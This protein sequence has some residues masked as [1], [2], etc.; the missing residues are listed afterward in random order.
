[1]SIDPIDL[2]QEP[3]R[4]RY[5]VQQALPLLLFTLCAMGAI[6]V[7]ALRNFAQFNDTAA[8]LDAAVGVCSGQPFTAAAA[9][10]PDGFHPVVVFRQLDDGRVLGDSTAVPSAWQPSTPSTLAIVLCITADRDAYR[11]L[12]TVA[13]DPSSIITPYGRELVVT[14]RAA[15]TA[16]II[17][18]GLISNVPSAPPGCLRQQPDP[19]PPTTPVTPTDI[20]TWLSPW[21]GN[22]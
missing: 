13:G 9:Y 18:E 20:Q 8:V 11:P 10:T 12:C 7:V 16:A 4:G 22:N 6:G 3:G 15:Q 19:L 1:M 17:T 5:A 2:S 14:L 21:V